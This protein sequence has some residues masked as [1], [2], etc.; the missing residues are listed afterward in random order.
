MVYNIDS[1]RKKGENPEKQKQYVYEASYGN[2]YD[3]FAAMC[4]MIYLGRQWQNGGTARLKTLFS[5]GYH[6]FSAKSAGI[7]WNL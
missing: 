6:G 5:Q 7:H 3:K 4:G 2:Y 1:D